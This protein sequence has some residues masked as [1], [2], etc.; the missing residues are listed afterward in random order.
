M[1]RQSRVVDRAT[2]ILVTALCI[3]ATRMLA[4]QQPSGVKL[5]PSQASFPSTV[6][7]GPRLKPEW[8]R[9]EAPVAEGNAPNLALLASANSNHTFVFSTVAL[10]VIGVLILLLVL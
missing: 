4:A 8:P 6:L 7:S 1:I 5:G 9:F 10:V 2:L 3:G